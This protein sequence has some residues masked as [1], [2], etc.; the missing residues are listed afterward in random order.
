[1]RP[2]LTR[3]IGRIVLVSSLVL[4]TIGGISTAATAAE[5]SDL[6]QPGAL[7]GALAPDKATP[8]TDQVT[9]KQAPDTWRKSSAAG[10]SARSF[11]VEAEEFKTTTS[12][13]VDK[14]MSFIRQDGDYSVYANAGVTAATYAKPTPDGA[15]II[16]AASE[17]AQLDSFEVT[18]PIDPSSVDARPDGSIF[19]DQ[20]N[21]A[22]VFIRAPWARD[23]EGKDLPTRYELNGTQLHQ[24]VDVTPQTSF[25]VIADPAWDYTRD[26]GV[27][28]TT[29]ESAQLAMHGCF[30]C[31]FPVP[32]APRNFPSVGQYLPLTAG[33]WNFA[34]IFRNEDYRPYPGHH[35]WGF[36][37]DAA[38]G[39]V[40]GLGSWISFDFFQKAG[41]S[42]YTLR[43][44]GYIVNDNPTGVG[45]PAYLVGATANW[46][47]FAQNISNVQILT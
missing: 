6:L 28:S 43:V 20:T 9:L 19:V 16:F 13:S 14:T 7:V 5:T 40:D 44:Y 15:Q 12:V 26:Y 22:N 11:T 8:T 17:A 25:P 21:G 47:L 37:F 31:Y 29:P 27:G 41:E 3:P 32:G 23:A 10:A 35:A 2:S 30:N 46:Y 1:M 24:I 45:R 39:H 33:P 4:A 38:S 18:L 42:T 36:V 34:C